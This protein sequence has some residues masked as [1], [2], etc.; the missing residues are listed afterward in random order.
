MGDITAIILAAGRGLRMGPRGELHPKGFL[1]VGGSTLIAQSLQ[2]LR[3]WG[4]RRVI[5][6]TGHLADQYQTIFAG[7][8][9]ELAHNPGYAD[10]GS[11]LSL[12]TGLDAAGDGPCVILESDLIFAPEALDPVDA[13]RDCFVVSGPTGAGDEQYAWIDP[14]MVGEATRL[15][16]ISKDP[17]ARAERPYG[18]MVGITG[19]TARSTARMRTV[20][21]A[22]LDRDPAAHYEPGVVELARQ[23]DI[24][25]VRLDALP[26]AEIDDEDML[27]RAESVVYPR[28]AAARDARALRKRRTG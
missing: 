15:V 13:D 27:V 16:E 17:A 23:V 3:E 21:Q 22:V 25:V 5:I 12:V 26:W 10:T 2:A 18:E 7:T 4:A 8:D 20:A 6:V 14:E 11:L 9:V 1:N 28:V 24:D 19:L